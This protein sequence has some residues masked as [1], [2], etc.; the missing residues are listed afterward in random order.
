MFENWATPDQSLANVRPYALKLPGQKLVIDNGSV[1]S[2][3]KSPRARFLTSISWIRSHSRIWGLISAAETEAGFHNPVYAA[4][5][6][7]WTE[8]VKTM[9]KLTAQA[10]DPKCWQDGFNSLVALATPS[11]KIQFFDKPKAPAIPD[12]AVSSDVGPATPKDAGQPAA[13]TVGTDATAK[14]VRPDATAKSQAASAVATAAPGVS[15]ADAAANNKS[16]TVF[17]NLMKTTLDGLLEDMQQDCQKHGAVLCVQALP[18]RAI[19]SP[20]SGMDGTT[21]GTSYEGEVQALQDMC[22]KDNI[23]F[24]N[25]LK[26]ATVYSK[27]DQEKLFYSAHLTPLGH[28]YVADIL[29]P[30]L[31]EQITRK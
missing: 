16:A 4:I 31:I 1:T 9:K 26:P 21:Y 19:L 7:F 22:S 12:L 27:A 11:F 15:A 20:I 28:S 25:V 14:P 30:F 6:A 17:L 29:K 18:S 3:L 13:K 8:T 2:W 5:M 23:P 24:V 10:K